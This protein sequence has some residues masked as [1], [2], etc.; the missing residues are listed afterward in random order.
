MNRPNYLQI[1][2]VAQLAR[3]STLHVE[4]QWF[5]STLLCNRLWIYLAK[6]FLKAKGLG[7]KVIRLINL[8]DR[9]IQ[10]SK[11]NRVSL[12]LSNDLKKFVSLYSNGLL[13]LPL[14]IP[15]FFS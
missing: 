1:K 15:T 4:G 9:T 2:E 14:R 10:E 12:T 5:E 8:Q 7:S 6:I 13:R 3:A 11:D